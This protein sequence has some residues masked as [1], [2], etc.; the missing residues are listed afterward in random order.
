MINYGNVDLRFSFIFLT[1]SLMSLNSYSQKINLNELNKDIK[2]TDVMIQVTKKKMK[3]IG[4]VSFL[5]DLYFVLADLYHEK[6]RLTFEEAKL[7][8]PQ[9]KIEDLDNTASK[10]AKKL[11]IESYYRFTENY[12]KDDRVDKAFYNIALS[13]RELGQIEDMV[14]IY[15]KIT[16]EFPKSKY[17]EESQLRLGDYFFEV[18]KNTN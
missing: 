17:W 3:E 11:A 6:S 2:N 10:K 18:K 16:K 9:K 15:K 12:P 4:D 8:Q 7:K 14:N 1:L 13:Y 5:P